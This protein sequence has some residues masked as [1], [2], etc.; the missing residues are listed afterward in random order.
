MSKRN[1]QQTVVD[2][3]EAVAEMA[4]PEAPPIPHGESAADFIDRLDHEIPDDGD[5]DGDGEEQPIVFAGDDAQ[6]ELAS[7]LPTL[8]S[9]IAEVK[10]NPDLVRALEPGEII[11]DPSRNGR[12]SPR[13]DSDSDVKEL[14]RAIAENGQM[15]PGEVLLDN[16]GKMYLIFGFGRLAAINLLNETRHLAD[17]LPFLAYVRTG[18]DTITGRVRNATENWKRKELTV[19][20]KAQIVADFMAPPFSLNQTQI[21]QRLGIAK[22]TVSNYVKVAAFPQMVKDLM[23]DGGKPEVLGRKAAMDL[24]ALPADQIEAAAAK[25]VS[26]SG[27]KQITARDVKKKTKAAG[28]KDKKLD[29]IEFIEV[30]DYL[31]QK[32]NAKQLAEG[33]KEILRLVSDTVYGRVKAEALLKKLAV[34]Q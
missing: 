8:E 13:K 18:F 19:L 6:G 26:E 9:F 23:G 3:A 4:A 29:M 11:V 21:S 7:D 33:T 5:G 31:F 25:L 17:K 10:S 14:A 24:C 16:D 28:V 2:A 1:K 20:D 34:Y 30:L 27:G 32:A 12:T 15:Q 22:A